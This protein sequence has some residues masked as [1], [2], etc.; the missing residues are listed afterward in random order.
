MAPVGGNWSFVKPAY[1]SNQDLKN[2]RSASV[3]HFRLAFGSSMLRFLILPDLSGFSAGLFCNYHSFPKVLF[4]SD[5][6]EVKE[7]ASNIFKNILTNP[8]I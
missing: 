3:S 1:R 8:F 2:I 4:N 6:S 5:A 7:K